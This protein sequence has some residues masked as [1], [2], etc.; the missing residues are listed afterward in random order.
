MAKR[1][2]PWPA[3]NPICIATLDDHGN[4]VCACP[5]APPPAPPQDSIY[6]DALGTTLLSLL[7]RRR[8]LTAAA[9]GATS[10]MLAACGASQAANAA[11]PGSSTSA[12]TVASRSVATTAGAGT[13]ASSAITTTTGSA[14]ASATSTAS[15]NTTISTSVATTNSAATVSSTG[16]AQWVY[17][18][19]VG[20]QDVTI[21]DAATNKVLATRPLGAAVR[22]LSNE[23]RYWDGQ[24][25]WT[26]DFPDNKLV[27]IAIDP[28]TVQVV[29]RID[30]GTLGPGHSLMLT[31]D[32]KTAYVNAAGSNA[33]N[34]IDVATKAVKDKIE[35][36]SF[37]CDC[38]LSPD[39]K[40]GYTPERDQDTV[41]KFDTSTNKIIKRMD[42]PKGSKPYMLRVSPDGKE[43]WVQA[44]GNN[45]NNIVDPD[46]LTILH[47][48]ADG[49]SPVTNAW[50]PD[51]KYVL[52]THEKD[53]TVTVYDAKSQKM[54]KRIT[55]GQD[56][57]NIGFTPDGKKAFIAVT[58]AN[59]VA[60]IDLAS[61][62]VVTQVPA[63]KSP[64]G[65]IVMPAPEG[66]L[67]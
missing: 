5:S 59:S 45:T 3:R 28:K 9:G 24:H 38:H 1:T 54:L 13:T 16:G 51:G 4:A 23:Q 8:F 2:R 15:Q 53:E 32:F 27:A 48:E 10:L 63:G 58:G 18:F 37:P 20:S 61:L 66:G 19:N 40:F 65:L 22:W 46:N 60:I 64:Q 56:S 7:G 33:I 34:V 57:T 25:V 50:S 39:G 55:V 26:Y 41:A 67:S 6:D 36:G 47:S 43:V 11:T 31:P 49:Q 29:S 44:A 12:G 42:F 21:L 17:V 14:I 30:T 35:V 52:L 62:T